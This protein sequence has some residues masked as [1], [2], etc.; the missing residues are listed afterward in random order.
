MEI[1]FYQMSVVVVVVV[2]F[3]S[4]FFLI[5]SVI[6]YK[7]SVSLS[8]NRRKTRANAVFVV[9]LRFAAVHALASCSIRSI[10]LVGVYC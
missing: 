10:S 5:H 1:V 7:K 3:F 2:A 9:F 4:F 6:G 8:I